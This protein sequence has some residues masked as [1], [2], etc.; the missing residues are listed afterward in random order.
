VLLGHPIVANAL[1]RS[2]SN[3]IA[4]ALAREPPGA[5]GIRLEEQ[6]GGYLVVELPG[7]LVGAR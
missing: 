4:K 3:E 7:L 6:C 1:V 5:A 2:E